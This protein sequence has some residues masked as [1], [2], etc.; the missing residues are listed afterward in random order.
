[1]KFFSVILVTALAAFGSASDFKV[2]ERA[3]LP[4]MILLPLAQKSSRNFHEET[5]H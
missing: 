4:G 5:S 1:M 2:E 3:C